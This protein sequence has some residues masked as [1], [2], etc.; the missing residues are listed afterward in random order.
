MQLSVD[1][2]ALYKEKT[3]KRQQKQKQMN[4]NRDP[5]YDYNS[6]IILFKTRIFFQVKLKFC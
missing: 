6:I 3:N 1:A 5:V 4:V 2:T